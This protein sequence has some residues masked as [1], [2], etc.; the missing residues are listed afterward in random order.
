MQSS[1]IC[2]V[3]L[4]L[5]L[6]LLPLLLRMLLLLT[7][8]L[9][10]WCCC[11]YASIAIDCDFAGVAVTFVVA[12]SIAILIAVALGWAVTILVQSA[13]AVNRLLFCIFRLIFF[14][15]TIKITYLTSISFAYMS[16]FK[17][18]QVCVR[19]L[20]RLE[21]EKRKKLPKLIERRKMGRVRNRRRPSC[22][23]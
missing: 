5:L 20:C 2:K 14:H 12:L 10:F 6:L 22:P 9:L 3:K 18:E 19:V 1:N 15:E 21:W 17:Q 8:R 13:I 4:L 23:I 7:V 16:L 11:D